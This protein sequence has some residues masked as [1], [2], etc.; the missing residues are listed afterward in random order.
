MSTV[1]KQTFKSGTPRKVNDIR[2]MEVFQRTSTPN[3]D[4]KEDVDADLS[5]AET[6]Y[7]ETTNGWSE[8]EDE[9]YDSWDALNG[10]EQLANVLKTMGETG[11]TREE[12]NRLWWGDDDDNPRVCRAAVSGTYNPCKRKV[13]EV[14]SEK[15]RG[16]MLPSLQAISA[17]LLMTVLYAARVARYDLFKPINFLAKRITKWDMRPKVTPL[18]VVHK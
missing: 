15:L 18:N 6:E 10:Q 11:I 17:M 7:D 9:E 2:D 5:E 12:V 16:V 1:Q 14:S 8:S 13:K 3:I 4:C